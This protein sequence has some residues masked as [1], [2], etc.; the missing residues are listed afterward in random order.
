MKLLVKCMCKYNLCAINLRFLSKIRKMNQFNISY[1]QL[2]TTK[3]WSAYFT[4][5]KLGRNSIITIHCWFTVTTNLFTAVYAK[6]LL[7]DFYLNLEISNLSINRFSTYAF[8]YTYTLCWMVIEDVSALKVHG[9]GFCAYD[10][11]SVEIWICPASLLSYV[12]HVYNP[13]IFE[14]TFVKTK[15]SI[16]YLQPIPVDTIWGNLGLLLSWINRLHWWLFLPLERMKIAFCITFCPSHFC[17][18]GS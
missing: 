15:T 6:S 7:D 12:M 17:L 8:W 1:H 5:K 13:Q 2:S 18:P 11:L 9:W 4:S 16:S 14:P 10:W 3:Y